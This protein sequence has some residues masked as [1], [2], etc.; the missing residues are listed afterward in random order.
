MTP[1]P[2]QR[3]I[4]DTLG[5]FAT[6][7]TVITTHHDGQDYGLTVN[8]FSS[9]SL[10]PP[11][12]LWSL[13]NSSLNYVAMTEC[14][15]FAVNIMSLEQKDLCLSFSR[16]VEDRFAGVSFHRQEGKTPTFNDNLA[17]LLCTRVDIFVQGDHTTITGEIIASEIDDAREPLLYYA[18]KFAK[19]DLS[20]DTLNPKR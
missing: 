15:F 8:S 12:V 6:G 16:P 3:S 11:L 2:D 10:S 17:T 13:Q 1:N 19:I 18:G 7:I 9:L 14:D 4:R 20:D 5:R